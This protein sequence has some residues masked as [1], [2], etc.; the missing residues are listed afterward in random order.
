MNPRANHSCLSKQR[1]RANAVL[2]IH[3]G[4]VVAEPWGGTGKDPPHPVPV[5][6]LDLG[7]QPGIGRKHGTLPVPSTEQG[8]MLSSLRCGGAGYGDTTGPALMGLW[9]MRTQLMGTS[10]GRGS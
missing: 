10:H 1:G 2:N 3:D 4:E 5:V 9:D 7:V 8:A 6:T